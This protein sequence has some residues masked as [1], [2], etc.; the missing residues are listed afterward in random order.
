MGEIEKGLAK[1]L[2]QFFSEELAAYYEE[3]DA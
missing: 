1:I 2:R 3:E